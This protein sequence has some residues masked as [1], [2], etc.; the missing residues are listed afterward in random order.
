MKYLSLILIFC[1]SSHSIN[2]QVKKVYSLD[3]T[4]DRNVLITS[5]AS[6]GLGAYLRGQIRTFEF[7]D[8]IALDP[9]G[10]NN[11][12]TYALGK[13]S[14]TANH[15]SDYTLYLSLGSAFAASI[16]QNNKSTFTTGLVMY[17][18]VFLLNSGL[19]LI[20]KSITQRTRPLVYNTTL[21]NELKINKNSRSSFP[22][23][24][25]SLSSAS[26]FFAAKLFADS[27]PDSKLKPLV[28]GAAATLPAVTGYLRIQ[29]GKHFPTDVIAGYILGAG[30]G[31][32]IPELHRIDQSDS[33]ALSYVI[34]PGYLAMQYNF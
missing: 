13:F 6:V 34:G 20:G 29:A 18:E 32:I 16:N 14:E 11:F 17:A 26:C 24:H 2:G 28:W 7:E 22:S 25:T 19:T 9:S 5:V 3:K 8:I 31:L 4:T 27:H 21:S 33:N 10:I 23:G 30:I 15:W 1:F 12:D